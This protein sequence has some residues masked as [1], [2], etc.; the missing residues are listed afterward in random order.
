MFFFAID[1]ITQSYPSSHFED[2]K[3]C[4][5]ID[6]GKPSITSQFPP[7]IS[8]RLTSIDTLPIVVHIIHDGH[9]LGSEENPTNSD[10]INRIQTINDNFRYVSGTTFANPF[11]GI[12][13][14]I[15]VCLAEIDPTGNYTKGIIRYDDALV[16]NNTGN[17]LISAINNWKWDTDKYL[18]LFLIRYIPGLLGTYYGGTTDVVAQRT[19]TSALLSVHEIGHYLDLLHTFQGGCTNN[20]CQTDGDQVCDT[21]PKAF[22]GLSGN[23]SNSG[24][25]CTTDVDDTSANNPYR[26]ISLGGLGDQPDLMENYMDYTEGCWGAFTQG[27]KVRMKAEIAANRQSVVNHTSVACNISYTPDYDIVVQ[28]VNSYDMACVNQITPEVTFEN[29]GDITLNSAVIEFYLDDSLA[30]S[31]NWSG[32]LITHNSTTVTASMPIIKNEGEVKL[33]VK[34]ITPNGQVD[35]F[36]NDNYLSTYIRYFITVPSLPYVTSYPEFFFPPFW[37]AQQSDMKWFMNGASLLDSCQNNYRLLA[38]KSENIGLVDSAKVILPPLNLEGFSAAHLSFDYGY[39]PFNSSNPDTLKVVAARQCGTDTVLWQKTGLDLATND[40]PVYTNTYSYPEC[41]QI[42]T[43][44]INLTAFTCQSQITIKFIISGYGRTSLI[45]D[46]VEVLNDAP[47]VAEGCT[48]LTYPIQMQQDVLP[49]QSINW[50][51]VTNAQGYKVSA[52]YESGLYSIVADFNVGLDTFYS[53]ENPF[54]CDTSVY[55]KIIPYDGSGDAMG[56]TEEFFYTFDGIDCEF[57][58]NLATIDENMSSPLTTIISDLDNDG[59]ND[60]IVGSSANEIYSY[61]NQGNGSFTK[62]LISNSVSSVTGLFVVDID[63]DGDKDL[64]SSLRNDDEVVSWMNDGNQNF[65]E[66]VIDNNLDRAEDVAAADLDGDNDIDLVAVGWQI[67]DLYWYEND[68]NQN[69][70][71]HLI[72]GALFGATDIH[73]IDIEGDSDIDILIAAQT[74]D[75]ISLW[76]NDGSASFSKIVIDNNI[77]NCSGV[78]AGHLN[79]DNHLDIAACSRSDQV[80]WYENDGSLNF[81]EHVIDNMLDDVSE[82]RIAD[83]NLD[84]ISDIVVSAAGNDD[85]VGYLNDENNNFTKEIFLSGN[86]DVWSLDIA[87]INGNSAP[88]IAFGLFDFDKVSWFENSCSSSAETHLTNPQD[89]QIDVTYNTC[90]N[91]F[92]DPSATG[93]YVSI[94]SSTAFDDI[95]TYQDVGDVNQ[96]C[97]DANFAFGDTIHVSIYPYVDSNTISSYSY[98]YFVIEDCPQGLPLILTPIADGT[99]F[100]EGDLFIDE[101]TMNPNGNVTI[102]SNSSIELDAQIDIPFSAQLNLVINTCVND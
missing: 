81:I 72:N 4:G 48:Y 19:T 22:A 16:Y 25:S 21:P 28:E 67:A 49:D 102:I 78:Y 91:W 40:P 63:G 85:I 20:D 35:E 13:T 30:H 32:T 62:Q 11:S 50:M 44:N 95:F 80:K 15:E 41:W 75:E 74:R 29:N 70:T 98:N 55:V 37:E 84:N 66:V 38:L 26:E 1:S 36:E 9:A 89:Q 90:L 76:V 3:V 7:V 59:M 65:T 99:Y 46:N 87:D 27:Q 73:L 79:N 54:L 31:Q 82:I 58:Y 43:I 51:P 56:C 10:I 6:E 57:N 14:E 61:I 68:G 23:C 47:C 8:K 86:D 88:D 53:F 34:V 45:L 100:H 71:K 93:Y 92:D 12:D 64:L 17:E 96:L 69:F 94:G 39:L 83:I 77:E 97:L 42:E 60:V 24:N 5:H 2:V 33:T 18:N 52:G 101:L